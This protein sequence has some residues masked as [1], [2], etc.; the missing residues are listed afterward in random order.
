MKRVRQVP[1][2]SS[3]ASTY[4]RA[5]CD[6]FSDIPSLPCIPDSITLPSYKF[7][8]TARATAGVGING[9]GAVAFDPWTM[10]WNDAGLNDSPLLLSSTANSWFGNTPLPAPASADWDRAQSNSL[11]SYANLTPNGVAIRLVAA[12]IRISYTGTALNMGG[13][14][15]ITRLPSNTS[16]TG[17]SSTTL[18]NYPTT[19]IVPVTRSPHFVSY[20]PDQPLQIGYLT[21]A[22]YAFG[23]SQGP[24]YPL[25][26]TFTGV[27]GN[28]FHVEAVSY[29]EVIGTTYPPTPSHMD[30][31]GYSAIM[32]GAQTIAPPATTPQG[33]FA[34]AT[35]RV[36]DALVSGISGV[37]AN[38][39]AAAANT[40]VHYAISGSRSAM[41]SIQ[42]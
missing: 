42:L 17:I 4:L 19:T 18:T 3:C 15:Q 38:V 22:S 30:A 29:F 5:L 25:S 7:R 20:Y 36:G 33:W 21:T 6:P 23:G 40:A 32:T 11:F 35:Q 39:G 9:Y 34:A 14:L 37:A 1:H 31:V 13:R 27:P 24:L 8:T 41:R 16:V 2:L 10:S 12:G 26:F 28:S